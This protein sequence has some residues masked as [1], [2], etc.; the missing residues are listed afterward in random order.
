MTKLLEKAFKKASKLP[1]VEQNVLAKWLLEELEVEKEWEKR[2]AES[3]DVLGRLGD[4]A[5]EADRKGKNKQMD[6]NR[7]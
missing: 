5:L 1:E 3:E 2:F 6:F 7:L 4:E